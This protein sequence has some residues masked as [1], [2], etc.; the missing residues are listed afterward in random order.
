[1]LWKCGP[2]QTGRKSNLKEAKHPANSGSLQQLKSKCN[3]WN[4][5]FA[6]WGL[7]LRRHSTNTKRY[8]PKIFMETLSLFSQPEFPER[9]RDLLKLGWWRDLTERVNNEYYSVCFFPWKFR[10]REQTQGFLKVFLRDL[11]IVIEFLCNR[12][13]KM[14]TKN[15]EIFIS[16]LAVVHY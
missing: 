9:R 7:R 3:F 1:M 13:P 8:F 10:L 14:R 4:F 15:F 5:L 11:F 6:V 2:I 16:V 12:S